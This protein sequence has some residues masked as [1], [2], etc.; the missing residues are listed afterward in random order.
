MER[1]TKTYTTT[2]QHHAV[3]TGNE[4]ANHTKYT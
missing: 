2:A 1:R 3:K 4:L